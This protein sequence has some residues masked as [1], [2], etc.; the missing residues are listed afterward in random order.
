MEKNLGAN[1]EAGKV[2]GKM[3]VLLLVME[4]R[5]GAVGR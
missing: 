3:A 2:G 4:C 5:R 1:D